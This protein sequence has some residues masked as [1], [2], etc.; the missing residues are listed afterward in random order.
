MI[1]AVRSG[2]RL[3]DRMSLTHVKHNYQLS[4]MTVT[5]LRVGLMAIRAQKMALKAIG[6]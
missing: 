4:T 2:S 6:V 3:L 1:V 5:V